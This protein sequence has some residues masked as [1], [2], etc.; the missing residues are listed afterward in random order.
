MNRCVD[1]T[2]LNKYPPHVQ[3]DPNPHHPMAWTQKEIDDLNVEEPFC[4]ECAVGIWSAGI[5]PS[6]R[7]DL[8]EFITRDR[9]DSCFFIRRSRGMSIPGAK[10]LFEKHQ[11]E[12]IAKRTFLI[13]I[14]SIIVTAFTAIA[15]ILIDITLSNSIKTLPDNSEIIHT[16]A[17]ITDKQNWVKTL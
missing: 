10:A 17:S 7:D 16:E 9:K 13:A 1:C 11:K 14:I 15:S 12:M 3:G 6:I 5:D 8:K 4:P 2:F